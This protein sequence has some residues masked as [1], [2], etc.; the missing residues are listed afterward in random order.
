M[1]NKAWMSHRYLKGNPDQKQ[2]IFL[3]G[4][5]GNKYTHIDE[6]SEEIMKQI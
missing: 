3:G 6:Q 1:P 4:L 5:T 2:D